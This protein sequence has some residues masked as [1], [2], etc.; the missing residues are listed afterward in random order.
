V[1]YDQGKGERSCIHQWPN[2]SNHWQMNQET[3]SS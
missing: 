2:D 3:D 1:S